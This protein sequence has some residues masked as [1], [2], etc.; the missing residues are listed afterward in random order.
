MVPS[1]IG[2]RLPSAVLGL[3]D[4]DALVEK[5]T[6]SL[7]G[8]GRAVIIGAPGAFTPACHTRHLPDF[9]ANADRLRAAGFTTIACITP[10]DP[11]VNAVWAKQG[12]PHGKIDILSDGNLDLAHALGLTVVGRQAHAGTRSQRY[13]IQ[14]REGLIERISVERNPF[15]VT[16]TRSEDVMIAI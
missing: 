8:C 4:G 5:T 12:D 14:L 2:K 11:W 6:E 16:C 9:V 13:L 1:L 15:A 3:L 7:F 10:N